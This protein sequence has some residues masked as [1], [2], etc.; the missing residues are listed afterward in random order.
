VVRGCGRLRRFGRSRLWPNSG[1]KRPRRRV[2]AR[3]RTPPASTRSLRRRRLATCRSGARSV[4]CSCHHARELEHV[5]ASGARVRRVLC[6]EPRPTGDTGRVGAAPQG[7]LGLGPRLAVE[8]ALAPR[9][10]RR[11]R[12]GRVRV[13]RALDERDFRAAVE[14]PVVGARRRRESHGR[15]C[16]R[17]LTAA[18]PPSNPYRFDSGSIAIQ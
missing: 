14:T 17:S 8:L 16:R 15:H 9:K 18:R 11:R 2:P 4:R 12:R 5:D 3:P 13:P 1:P 6:R 7:R 10:V